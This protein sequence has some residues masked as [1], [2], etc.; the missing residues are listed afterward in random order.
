MESDKNLSL[1]AQ[2][3]KLKE[4][5]KTEKKSATTFSRNIEQQNVKPQFQREKRR[6]IDQQMVEELKRLQGAADAVEIET[7]QPTQTVQTSEHS[8]KRKRVTDR[9]RGQEPEAG[10]P[11][12]E[13]PVTEEVTE[14]LGEH[15]SQE[16][17]QARALEREVRTLTS[18]DVQLTRQDATNTYTDV[19]AH[20][21]RKKLKVREED[22]RRVGESDLA[23]LLQ[24]YTEND[25]YLVG[26]D[27]ETK[28][29]KAVLKAL[30]KRLQNSDSLGADVRL[31]INRLKKDLEDMAG[32]K[33]EIPEDAQV[34][35]YSK[36]Q[37]TETGIIK[38]GRR[39]NAFINKMW[40]WSDQ[41]DTPLFSHE[42]TIN[43]LK[44]RLVSNCYMV[45]GA[46][47]LVHIN[48][49]LL[50]QCIKDNGDGTVTVRLYKVKQKPGKPSD[51]TD[52]P[53]EIVIMEKEQIE[54]T[55]NKPKELTEY[56]PVYI[57]VSKEIPRIAG[58]DAL[59]A[60]ALW[61]QMIEKAAAFLGKTARGKEVKGYQSLWYGEGGEFLGKLLGVD[62]EDVNMDNTLFEK[63][64]KCREEG[65]VY[66]TGTT[67]VVGQK[68]GLNKGHAYTIMGGK[69][70][71]GNKYV[72]LRNP[73][74]THSLTYKEDG[75]IS[76][77]G[78][79][80]TLSSDETYGQFYIKYEDFLSKFRM[81]TRTDLKKVGQNG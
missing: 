26:Y 81:V 69:E 30:K 37:P 4:E 53:D 23:N 73:Y 79:P 62:W 5:K 2:K 39:R 74:S 22:L 43:D 7:K 33:L 68:D 25:R 15:E 24:T 19:L 16:R 13:Q 66:N 17:I 31:C 41:K 50:K 32:G 40:Y 56:E 76:R 72:L 3:R 55:V 6:R 67:K 48:P 54:E 42:P 1:I 60:G 80:L 34:L 63:I 18:T 49:E 10:T 35:D 58:S 71:N 75:S 44:Q 46:A 14:A 27:K 65:F 59:S 8:W 11:I 61:M 64:C 9:Q 36:Q 51:D 20:E 29:L 38:K 21:S 57:K 28:N 52:D 70:V 77:T 78:V 45:A 12:Q 47:G